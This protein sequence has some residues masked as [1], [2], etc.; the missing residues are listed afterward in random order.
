MAD[1]TSSPASVSDQRSTRRPRGLLIWGIVALVVFAAFGFLVAQNP[2]HPFI[3][4]LD[5]AWRKLVGAGPEPVTNAFPMFFQYLG[6]PPTALI[7]S[8]GLPL[9][10]VL[11]GRWRQGIFVFVAGLVG[12]GLF[13]Q[14]A[15]QLV[16]RPRPAENLD[17]GLYGPLFPVDHGSFPSGHAVTAGVIA[18]SVAAIIPAGRRLVWWII[19]SLIMVGMVWQRT[20]VNAHWL[21]DAVFGLVAGVAAA[22]LCWWA[23]YPM[24]VRDY[25]RPVWFLRRGAKAVTE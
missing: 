3:Q 5:D 11:F 23:F 12:P 2:E 6:Q 16:D 24:I 22:L 14:V 21:S 13:S 10:L 25:G 18:L 19:G 1:S 9:V 20:L 7:V 17:L 4:P 15:K 8:F